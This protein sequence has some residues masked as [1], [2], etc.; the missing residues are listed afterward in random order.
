MENKR[1]EAYFSTLVA[2][3]MKKYMGGLGFQRIHVEPVEG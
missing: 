3:I 1:A 2:K